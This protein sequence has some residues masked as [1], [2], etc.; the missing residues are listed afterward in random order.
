MG[1]SLINT[2]IN[3]SASNGILG[4]SLINKMINTSASNGIMKIFEVTEW[5]I[6]LKISSSF[7]LQ[8][9]I[10]LP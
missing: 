5:L 9:Q 6:H 2:M 3:T 8:Q 10:P 7:Y 1:I 4:I